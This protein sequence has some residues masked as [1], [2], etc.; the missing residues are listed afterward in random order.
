[1]KKMKN[2]LSTLLIGSSVLLGI[3]AF[4]QSLNFNGGYTSSWMRIDGWTDGGSNESY[5]D[6]EYSYSS[7]FNTKNTHGFNAAIGYEFRLGNRLS[8]ETGFKYQT[9]G[10]QMVYENSY[11]IF[12]EGYSETETSKY[13]Y[14]MNYLDLPVV[15]NIAI[16][17]GDFRLYA[18]TGIYAGLLTRAKYSER[19]EYTS[20]LGESGSYEYAE[21]IP[22]SDIDERITGGIVVGIGAEYKGFYFETNYNAGVY[23]LA[24]FDEE[25]Y[26]HDLSF[27]LGYKI[28]FKREK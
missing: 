24:D 19:S 27:S 26:T 6:G 4:G 21:I 8:L 12:S 15:L 13:N 16:L 17:T 22:G 28:K 2:T 11:E 23:S 25:G 9:R 3:S 10:F 18:R 7:S 20:S 5:N 14:K 1:M